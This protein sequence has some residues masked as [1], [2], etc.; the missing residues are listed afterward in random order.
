MRTLLLNSSREFLGVV[1]WQQA[2]GDIVT[3][4]VRAL[5]HYDEVIRSQ[6]L[7]LKV[8]AVVQQEQMVHVRWEHIFGISHTPRN[9][10]I[11]D[12][13]KCQY[14]GKDCS[15]RSFT[16]KELSRQPK[17]IQHRPEVDHVL[18]RSRG[19]LD[20]WQNT[21]TSCRRCNN[22]KG[23]RTPA[24]WGVPLANVP[25]KPKDFRKI[26]EMKIGQIH[27]LWYDFLEIYF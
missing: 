22:A 24:E 25:I 14:C 10:F 1:S 21:V 23:D 9:V 5:R 27:E 26:F 19:G 16:E 18:P 7:A 11:R 6:H 17:L 8:P 2:V 12:G 13:Y 4:Q 20:T 3:G 15:R